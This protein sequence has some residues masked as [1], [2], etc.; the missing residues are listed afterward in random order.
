MVVVDWKTGAPPKDEAARASRELQLAVYRLAWSRWTGTPLDRV[1]AAFCYVGAGAT[2][3]PD[4]LLDEAEITELLRCRDA[5]AG[6]AGRRRRRTAAQ[7]ARLE[8][9]RAHPSPTGWE[10]TN[11]APPRRSTQP[12][13]PT[14]FD[15]D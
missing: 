8:D 11:A 13:A 10:G 3:Y 2:V 12:A 4:R 14:L 9:E 7:P 1:R 15:V 5:G 6:S